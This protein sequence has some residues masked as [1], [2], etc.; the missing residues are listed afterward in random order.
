QCTS[1]GR[2]CASTAD[3]D[4]VTMLPGGTVIASGKAISISRPTITIPVVGGTGR[5]E[6]A[7]GTITISPSSTKFSTFR[8]IIP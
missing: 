4:T 3:F 5:Y 7:R 2:Q 8:L 1:F 6:G